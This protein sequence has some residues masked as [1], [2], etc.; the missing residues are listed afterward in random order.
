MFQWNPQDYARNSSCQESLAKD[1]LTL[2]AVRVD[3]TVLDVGCGD[4]RTTAAI[5]AAAADGR[6]TGVDLSGEMIQHA[7]D[8]YC[9]S[10]QNLT[11]RQ[12][13]AAQLPFENQFSLV[14]SNATLHWVP[15]QRAAVLGIA[16]ALISGGRV[17]AQ[18]GGSPGNGTEVAEAFDEVAA[19][20]RWRGLLRPFVKAYYFQEPRDYAEWLAQAG[21]VIDE[22]RLIPK[23]IQ[24]SGEEAFSGW[25]RT[26]WH[27]YTAQAKSEL[28]EVLIAET[29]AR[30]L[31]TH[32][33]DEAGAI[34]VHMA[35]LQVRAHKP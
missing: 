27:P 25:L 34:R 22:C 30:Y 24:Y 18:F 19:S 13:D 20:P 32:P 21:L 3:E 10:H 12:A 16:R 17:V 1:L 8:R 6:V 29:I 26:A 35:R 9:A 4:G 7:C 23:V 28:R 33:K 14:F 31:A 2:A 15:D 5:A 11:F